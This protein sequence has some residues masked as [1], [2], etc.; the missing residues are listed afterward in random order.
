MHEKE[1]E[2]LAEDDAFSFSNN[3]E[4]ISK[5]FVENSNKKGENEQKNKKTQSLHETPLYNAKVTNKQEFFKPE[6]HEHGFGKLNHRE[7]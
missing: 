4:S 5:E 1:G 3:N 6:S 7:V 2:Y